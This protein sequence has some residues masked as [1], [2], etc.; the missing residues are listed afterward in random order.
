MPEILK[1]YPDLNISQ[2]VARR[3]LL[4][5][6]FSRKGKKGNVVGARNFQWKGGRKPAMHYYR[7]QAYEIAAICEGKP[8]RMGEVI[9]HNDE[10]KE[11]NAPENL[12]VFPTNREHMHYHQQLLAF[13][14]EGREVDTI[15]LALKN[16]GRRLQRPASLIGW[17]PDIEKKSLLEKMDR[18]I[19]GQRILPSNV[20]P[21]SRPQ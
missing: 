17:K 1:D 8:L 7:R 2:E 5:E 20:P 9:H 18:R 13:Q 15:Q 19:A 4:R 6:G 12:L 14:R 16:G 3:Q 11:N 21:E 10:V